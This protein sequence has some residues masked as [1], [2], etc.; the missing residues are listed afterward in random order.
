MSD[1][2]VTT[3]TPV[4]PTTDARILI[5]NDVGGTPAFAVTNSTDL[6]NKL[7]LDLPGLIVTSNI[8]FLN[9]YS[10]LGTANQRRWAIVNA[11]DQLAIQSQNDLLSVLYTHFQA[12]PTGRTIIGNGTT[13]ELELS[14]GVT[15]PA[16]TASGEA[17]QV[18][19]INAATGQLQ[20]GGYEV[21]DT[22]WRNVTSLVDADWTVSSLLIRRTGNV[23]QLTVDNLDTVNNAPVFFDPP[24]G[25][26]SLSSFRFELHTA[27]SEVQRGYTQ[28][29]PRAFRTGT[30]T[31][32]GLD[33]LYGTI[34]WLTNETW[35]S[36]LPGT[37]V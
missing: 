2:N 21:G 5:V 11:G 6:I 35:P 22:D 32:S 12:L 30:N 15:V 36:T 27:T 14:T 16:A 10:P 9:F 25:F 29:S 7:N 17:V 18:S 23:C 20:I 28:N 31:P 3:Q 13:V 19:A 24:T 1:V 34:T 37:A 33:A 26:N 8:S 4:T